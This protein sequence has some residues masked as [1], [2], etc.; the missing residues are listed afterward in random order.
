MKA[1][2]RTFALVASAACLFGTGC[3][4]PGKPTQQFES[5]PDQLA[6]F[7][8]LY[9]QNCAAC[10][11]ERGQGGVAISLANPVYLATAG[12]NTIKR[13]TA[14]GV[15]G[16][17][18]PPFGKAAGGMLTD[19]QIAILAEGMEHSWGRP[20]SDVPPYASTATGDAGRGQVAYAN[21]CARCHGAD[22]TGVNGMHTGSIVDPSYLVLV[23]DQGLGTTIIAGFP[24]QGMPDWRSHVV[25]SGSQA[26]S[27]QQVT[28]IVVWIASHRVAAPGQP[29]EQR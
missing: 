23:S 18:M 6:D 14:A 4:P 9:K 11:G 27:E 28:D 19:R 25:G 2:F 26:M 1:C 15:R 22:G 10:H 21:F 8:M 5:R 3:S 12:V 7:D 29:Y 24:Y 17:A 20:E 13:V 16:T